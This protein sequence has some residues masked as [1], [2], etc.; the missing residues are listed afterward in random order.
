[1]KV[2]KPIPQTIIKT[3]VLVVGGGIAGCFAAIKAR[4][5]GANVILADK[6]Y[7]G[8]S[9]QTPHTNTF[10]AFNPEVH[11]IENWMRVCDTTGDY[12]N[13]RDWSRM[14]YEQ[15]T[16]RWADLVV[17]GAYVY[18]WDH[19]GVPYE[20]VAKDEDQNDMV[21]MPLN[22]VGMGTVQFQQS[23]RH[24]TRKNSEVM[25]KQAVKVGV[26]IMDRMCIVELLKQDGEIVG[27]VGISPDSDK[28]FIFRAKAT[29]LCAGP[30]GLKSPGLRCMSTGDSDAMGYRAGCTITGKEWEE[31]HP[32]RA[33][34]PAWPWAVKDR[35][36]LRTF[37]GE[38]KPNTATINAH[39]ENVGIHWSRLAT[40]H[41]EPFQVFE[42]NAPIVWEVA[43]GMSEF[44]IMNRSPKGYPR[45]EMD[46]RYAKSGRV[47]VVMGRALG[48]SAHVAD[49]IW[50]INKQCESEI[51]GLYAAGDS[52]GARAVGAEYPGQGFATA[53]CAVT[54]AISGEAAAERAAEIPE[55]DISEQEISRAMEYVFAPYEREGGFSPEWTTQLMQ[56]MIFPY[57][58]I[59]VKS[60]ERLQLALQQILYV[61]KEI[62]PKLTAH[63]FH[64]L[65]L[66]HET[67]NMA[68]NMEMKLRASIERKESRGAHFREDYPKRDDPYGLKWIK[69]K[70]EDGAMT[71]TDEPIPEKWW[72]DFNN[73]PYE[74]LYKREFPIKLNG[75]HAEG[76]N[77]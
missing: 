41:L 43:S 25:R 40:H 47:R 72:P 30:A 75:K 65:R 1:V 27:A 14:V 13:D 60:E 56:S 46:E 48:Q 74:E 28:A 16:A 45:S 51:P 20:C 9:G 76:R 39:E 6:G 42:G 19:D 66:A 12:M 34:F 3:D 38:K 52:L 4:E 63:D 21:V 37:R 71:L 11:D 32:V 68:L 53:F 77:K 64:E 5:K 73:I 62:I 70:D 8:K 33:D 67:R 50:P 54:G 10:A 57:Y 69:I 23:Y 36:R 44:Q 24:P 18:R 2:K 22:P 15:S 35:D 7:V 26:N 49:G 58:V 29:I 17:W 55:T 59:F 61:Q 31:T